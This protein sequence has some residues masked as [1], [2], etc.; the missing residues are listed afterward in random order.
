[1][2]GILTSQQVANNFVTELPAF[3]NGTPA[4][5]ST[6]P[7]HRWSFTN[8]ANA[9]AT[10]L[11]VTDVG[12]ANGTTNQINGIIR[13][14]GGTATFTGSQLTLSGG[15]SA[16]A[17]YV[18]F[19]NALVSALS[20]NHGGSGQL[21][22]EAWLTPQGAGNWARVFECGNTTSGKIT[23]PGGSFTGVNYFGL[24]TTPGGSQVQSAVDFGTGNYLFSSVV[25][26]NPMHMAMTWDDAT[27]T[28]AVK[29]YENGVQVAAMTASVR[30]TAINDLNNWLGR[31]TFS[32]DANLQG[33]V[34]EFR[35]FNR[36]LS[37]A[38]LMNDYQ[39]GPTF[40]GNVIKWNGNL[41]TNWD[42]NTTSNWLAGN[43][44][45]RFENGVTVQFDDTLSGTTN[46]VLAA[47]VRP[48]AVVVTNAAF[49]YIFSGSNG[50]AGSATLT[51]L[52]VGTLTLNN[53]NAYTGS[54]IINGGSLFVNGSLA[55]G[56]AVSVASGTTLGGNGVIN[57]TVTINSGGT[58]APGIGGIGILTLGAT[59]SLN[60][61]TLME[62]NRGA[63]TNADKIIRC[64]GSF[65][66]AGTLIVT[67][68][69][70]TLQSG[71][72]F[73]LFAATSFSGSFSSVALPPLSAGL[74][75][76]TNNLAVNGTIYV[77]N[78]FYNLTYNAGANGGIS[79]S[80]TQSVIY[81]GSGMA[82]TAVPNNGYAF[83][84][85]S[86][87]STTNP[88]TDANITNNLTVTANFVP[89]IYTLTYIAGSNGNI[90]ST[91]SQSVS[92]GGS[93]TAVTAMPNAGYAFTNWSDGLTANPRTDANVSSNL[94]VT[95]NFIS[96]FT[97]ALPAPW[98]TNA[99]GSI[100]AA[101]SATYSNGLFKV[102][103]AGTNVSGTSDNFWYVNQPFTNDAT[104][105]AHVV[106][107]TAT[108]S[109]ALVG[110]MMRE[111]LDAGSRSV[112]I[113]LTPASQAQWV[114]RSS[115]N[116]NSSAT[117]ASGQS[118]PYWLALTRGT[119]TFTGYLSSD[120]VTWVQLASVTLGENTNYYLGLAVCS[121]TGSDL[122][123][124]AFDN[125][126]ATNSANIVFTPAMPANPAVIGP[127]G[128]G[129]ESI[130]FI[131][132]GDTNSIWQLEES[133]DLINWTPLQT[134]GLVNQ[135]LQQ[136]EADDARPARFL[137]LRWMP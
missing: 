66:F 39:L 128:L 6:A 92:F 25:T 132:S 53:S 26:G 13:N 56:S 99:I 129:P 15:S 101:T 76:N 103:G 89:L 113:G 52:G 82:V 119:N 115:A 75:W 91:S 71:D 87:G 116:A 72:T 111:S 102:V 18:D 30:M 23:A 67:N 32:S 83:T 51:K 98:T 24:V 58:I 77:T 44:H 126:L 105:L 69:G 84:N 59:P 117:T 37:P 35:I 79:G 114:R 133:T 22:V 57:G 16:T 36:L 81:A 109:S 5:L 131:V 107:Q 94:T 43:L 120:G 127:L 14:N 137:R 55:A 130:N 95:A 110:V 47:A 78:I 33:S 45:V 121:G 112:F 136:V 73:N 104:L 12:A 21:T 60:G 1:M 125:V 54:T 8:A 74:I 3:T 80:A 64:S 10:G 4:F 17:P 85:W 97:G 90:S 124:S 88:R 106:G 11:V 86:D 28:G 70:A 68:L 50:I 42:V 93:G 9:N 65:T 48:A 134:V 63:A 27:N 20:T 100:A 49:N 31:S 38:E 62:I 61:R 108:N 2:D 34:A 41:A 96:I 46:V 122:N 123:T 118:A 40:A 135:T 29:V 19:T 7:V